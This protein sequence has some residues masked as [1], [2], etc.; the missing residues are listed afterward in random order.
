MFDGHRRRQHDEQSTIALTSR[1]HLRRVTIDDLDDLVA[2]DDDPEV[3]RF[4]NDGAPVDPTEVL[5]TLA[6]WLAEYEAGSRFG[7]WAAIDRSSESFLGWFHLRAD[8]DSGSPVPELGYR[9]R[10][11]A[12]GRGLASEGSIALIDRAFESS[13]ISRVRAE[14]MAVHAA[15]RRVMEKS[16]MRFVRTFD[17]HW[18]VRIPG[19]EHGDVEYA[20]DRADWERSNLTPQRPR[21]AR[22]PTRRGRRPALG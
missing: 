9:L 17:S 1:M 2:L 18:P 6:S 13:P 5:E 16:G 10:R 12:W 14:T 15:S 22:L 19:D 11:D 20:I 4:I 8:H 7:C 3:M 21:G